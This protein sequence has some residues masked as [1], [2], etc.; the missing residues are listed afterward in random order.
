MAGA[1]ASRSAP[2]APA[3]P[4]R[5]AIRHQKACGSP[6]G[7]PVSRPARPAGWR[8]AAAAPRPRTPAAAATEAPARPSAPTDIEYDAVIIGSGMG[9]LSTAAQMASKGAKVVVLEK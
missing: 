1:L 4:R 3:A 8:R 7:R 9:G 2:V 5:A 6:A